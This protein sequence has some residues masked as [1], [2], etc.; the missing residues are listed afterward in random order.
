MNR[1]EK[2]TNGSLK[3]RDTRSVWKH[4][5]DYV[6]SIPRKCSRRTNREAMTSIDTVR[7]YQ[8]AALGG[9][10]I[11]HVLPRQDDTVSLVQPY[12]CYCPG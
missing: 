8:R 7:S 1:D 9:G 11:W 12:C 2:E 4:V 5:C 10:M 6:T 3:A